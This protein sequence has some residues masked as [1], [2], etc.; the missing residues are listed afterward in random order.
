MSAIGGGAGTPSTAELR[1]MLGDLAGLRDEAGVL[2]LYVST[3]AERG[4]R[5]SPR[6]GEI[7][8]RT[9][10]GELRA[11][12]RA[13]GPGARAATLEERLGDLTGAL[14]DLVDPSL[15][16]RGRALFVALGG[17]GVHRVSTRAPMGTEAVLEPTA[18]LMPLMAAVADEQPAGVV[19][20]SG[21]ALRAIHV[22]GSAAHEVLAASFDIPSEDWR[23]MVGPASTNPTLGHESESQRDLFA[24]RLEDHRRA[25][26]AEI[27]PR[28]WEE[29]RRRGWTRILVA[30]SPERAEA[31]ASHRPDGA[32][33]LVAGSRLL[34]ATLS[35][36]EV[37]EAAEGELRAARLAQERALTERVRDA[38]LAANGRAVVGIADTVG[39]LAEG[40]VHHLLLDPARRPAG[41]RAPDGRLVPE[42]EVPPG[43]DPAAMAP[44][45]H[46]M[47]RLLEMALQTDAQV[48]LLSGEAA[49]LLA[50]HGGVAAELR[51]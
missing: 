2:S 29:A 21:E 39:A 10:L 9:R 48:T 35:P 18:Y 40:G 30:A 6:E 46:L 16:G 49:G 44:E 38:A 17:G 15:E 8:L 31:L 19:S 25:R 3:G 13:Q 33:E 43:A 47:E 37:R 28:V 50:E 27:A 1:R 11:R 24:R 51:W 7:E 14:E 36:Q 41:A 42:G 5:R 32:P 22:R 45:P 4:R 26:L 23:P 20:I 34:A 12:V